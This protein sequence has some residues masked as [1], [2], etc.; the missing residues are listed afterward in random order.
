MRTSAL[1]AIVLLLGLCVSLA[2]TN[3]TKEKYGRFLEGELAHG[4]ERIERVQT[5]DAALIRDVLKSQGPKL[6][7]SLVWNNTLRRNYGLFSLFETRALG[8]TV[9]FVGIGG[10]FIPLT[11]R[12]ELTRALSRLNGPPAPQ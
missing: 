11:E 4:L 5:R 7:E 6:I 8:A 12:S 10:T 3:P 1:I 2:A 9:S